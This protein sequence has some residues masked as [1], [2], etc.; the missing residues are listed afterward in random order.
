MEWQI[1]VR[2]IG[3]SSSSYLIPTARRYTEQTKLRWK[4]EKSPTKLKPATR[5]QRN[6]LETSSSP[7][8]VLTFSV[9][10]KSKVLPI[11]FPHILKGPELKTVKLPGGD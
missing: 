7:G 2:L 11:E 10:R 5:K 4:D 8:L 9:W 6:G 1:I 3:E